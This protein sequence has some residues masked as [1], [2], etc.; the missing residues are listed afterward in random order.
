MPEPSADL[1]ARFRTQLQE[2]EASDRS[3]GFLVGAFFLV[4][5]FIR[6]LKGGQVRWWAVG[7]AGALL[8]LA[9]IAPS[10]LRQPKRAWLFLGFLL[11]MVVNPIVLG[12][13]FLVVITP[14]ALLMRVFGRDALHLRGDPDASTYW[15]SHTDTASDMTEQF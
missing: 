10:L 12:V 14:A 6:L 7:L 5:G 2:S 9:L 15:R 1:L 4:V 13:L 11:G 8:L 3:F